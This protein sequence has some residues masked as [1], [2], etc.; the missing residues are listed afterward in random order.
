M[1]KA[2][3]DYSMKSD[4]EQRKKVQEKKENSN[5]VLEEATK[6]IKEEIKKKKNLR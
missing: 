6:N 4:K 2:Q 3:D 1:R 5:R